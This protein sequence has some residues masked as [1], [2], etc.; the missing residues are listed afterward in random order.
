MKRSCPVLLYHH[1]SPDREITPQAFEAQLRYLLDQGYESLALSDVLDLTSGRRAFDKPAFAVT[2]DD[3]YA[4]NWAHAFPILKK[5]Q[6]KAT[7]YLVTSRVETHAAPRP[8]GLTRDTHADERGSGGFLS[9]NEARLMQESGLITFGSHTQTHRNFTRRA[10][11]ENLEQELRGSRDMIESHLRTPCLDFAWPWGDYEDAWL[12]KLTVAGY[13]SA[14]TTRAGANTVGTSPLEL[15]RLSMRRAGLERLKSYLSWN[16]R[17]L[18][19]DIVGMF[20]GLDRRVKQW[21]Q[22]ES[23][24]SHG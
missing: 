7:Y 11:Y 2:F 15:R 19:A 9:W 21:L 17:A 13:R 18:T 23:P 14:V 5:L 22:K 1:V 24:Y 12:P 8:L 6:V 10:A 4:D 3:G 16:D 20:Y